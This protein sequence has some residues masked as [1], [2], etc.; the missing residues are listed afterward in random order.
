MKPLGDIPD[1]DEVEPKQLDFI[2]PSAQQKVELLQE[3]LRNGGTIHS[4]LVSYPDEDL[5]FHK[6]NTH[7]FPDKGVV[8]V[9]ADDKD[10]WIPG[11]DIGVLERHYE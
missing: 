2:S 11:D 9:H 5:H 6:F 1:V 4:Y 7:C 3:L 10:R 8:Y